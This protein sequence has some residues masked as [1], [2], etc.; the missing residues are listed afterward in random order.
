V[1][2]L[3]SSS[4]QGAAKG[5][6]GLVGK[7]CWGAEPHDGIHPDSKN[8]DFLFPEVDEGPLQP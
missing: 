4:W 5:K 8:E 2:T 3:A 6:G 1:F 7:Q